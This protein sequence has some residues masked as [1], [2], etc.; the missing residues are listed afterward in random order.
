M[1]GLGIRWN[2]QDSLNCAGTNGAIQSGD[3][4]MRFSLTRPATFFASLRGL[5]ERQNAGYDV[6]A[7][8]L[9]GDQIAFLQG[10]DEH[11]GCA[12]VNVSAEITRTLSA[13][14]YELQLH[15]STVDQL[16]HVGLFYSLYTRFQ[17]YISECSAC[18]R[19]VD[20][21]RSCYQSTW[22]L[23]PAT[24]L[25]TKGRFV[26]SPRG[27]PFLNRWTWLSSRVWTSDERL[28]SPALG[29]T[30]VKQQWSN[31]QP[32]SPFPTGRPLGGVDCFDLPVYALVDDLPALRG[33]F[34]LPCYDETSRL[35]DFTSRR[36]FFQIAQVIELHYASDPQAAVALQAATG[37]SELVSEFP[38]MAGQVPGGLVQITDLGT[39]IVC[40]GTTDFQ[41]LA[42]QAAYG[43][44]APQNA[45]LYGTSP[46][47]QVAAAAWMNRLFNLGVPSDRPVFFAGHSMGGA[48]CC[49]LAAVYRSAQADRLI[50]LLT[51]GC[52]VPGDA[53]LSALL[54]SVFRRHL[55]AIGDIVP[56]FPSDAALGFPTLWV[57]SIAVINAWSQWQQPSGRIML[58]P[59]GELR[60]P[61][62]DDFNYQTVLTAAAEIIAG[63][64]VGVIGPHAIAV[65]RERLGLIL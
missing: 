53:R 35:P 12:M 4:V 28:P 48:V 40:D 26:F 23:H 1:A 33:G 11:L 20:F 17:T 30:D 37:S 15:T 47:W 34:P 59:S 24:D 63:D 61:A 22:R 8:T 9:N 39:Y 13:G 21:L 16:Y 3:A 56:L 38:V 18:G 32:P 2:A 25:E 19:V 10:T 55:T 45:G 36:W 49:L 29:E 64:P 58:Y 44:Q 41:Q 5:V 62:A 46:T 51:F 6:A 31:G 50:E 43:L 65:Y 27:T 7:L 60:S 57:P 14:D 54:T 42:L 52:P